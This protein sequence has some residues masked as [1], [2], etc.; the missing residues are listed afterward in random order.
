MDPDVGIS[1]LSP[2]I[3]IWALGC[4]FWA[5]LELRM[6]FEAGDDGNEPSI[7]WI[8]NFIKT[9]QRLQFASQAPPPRVRRL[10]E[11]CWCTETAKRPTAGA[12]VKELEMENLCGGGCVLSNSFITREGTCLPIPLE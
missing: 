8:A 4:T 5:V 11:A 9:E 7:F 10:I 1:G 3:D 2:K 6:P 12:C